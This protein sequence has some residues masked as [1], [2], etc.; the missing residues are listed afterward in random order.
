MEVVKE[1]RGV[2]MGMRSRKEFK[3]ECGEMLRVVVGEV[4]DVLGEF[5]HGLV[6]TEYLFDPK[7]LVIDQ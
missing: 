3:M 1:S 4:R 6:T 7:E 5:C 2:V